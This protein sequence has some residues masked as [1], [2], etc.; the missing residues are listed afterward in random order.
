MHH[1]D[2]WGIPV[3][4][5]AKPNCQATTLLQK[6]LA[7]CKGKGVHVSAWLQTVVLRIWRCENQAVNLCTVLCQKDQRSSLRQNRNRVWARVLNICHARWSIS[8]MVWNQFLLIGVFFSLSG[9]P[10]MPLARHGFNA[11]PRTFQRCL[12]AGR[13]SR[14]MP[15]RD[16]SWRE[17]TLK[18]MRGA[19]WTD[20]NRQKVAELY[21]LY[22]N[23]RWLI[24]FRHAL[25]NYEIDHILDCSRGKN[26]RTNWT[27]NHPHSFHTIRQGSPLCPF[28]SETIAQER[29]TFFQLTALWGLIGDIT[30]SL[31]DSA[32]DWLGWLGLP[33]QVKNQT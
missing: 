28:T 16:G 8:P 5:A 4:E 9:M 27:H 12:L 24:F 29:S 10:N 17:R 1:K 32:K 19:H 11:P 3:D 13:R 18:H 2:P 14:P 6:W 30:W 21:P 20:C 15:Q 26:N 31:P 23:P 7:T 22:S 25:L 33:H